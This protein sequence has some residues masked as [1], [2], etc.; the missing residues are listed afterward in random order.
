[1]KKNPLFYKKSNANELKIAFAKR[2]LFLGITLLASMFAMVLI[3]MPEHTSAKAHAIHAG[4]SLCFLTPFVAGVKG[5]G[6]TDEAFKARDGKAETPEAFVTRYLK[7][8]EKEINA[9]KDRPNLQEALKELKEKVE[10]LKGDPELV[11]NLKS[12]VE[13]INLAIVSIQDNGAKGDKSKTIRGQFEAWQTKNKATLDSIKAG[14]KADLTP[15][16]IKLNSPMTPANTYNSSAY[17][18]QVEYLPG[19]TEIVRTQP[20]FWD[21]VRKLRTGAAALVWVNKKNPEGAA[22]F[23]GPGVAKPGVSFEIATEISNA[24]KIAASEKCATELL[25]DIDGFMSWFESELK[26]QLYIE[27]NNKLM[28]GTLS[29]TVPA[30]IQTISV[31]YSLTGVETTNPNNWDAIIACVAQLRA[32]F[33]QGN[34]VAFLNP[35]DY[36]NM[37]LTKAVSQGQYINSIPET[38]ATIVEDHNI[39]VG[40]VQVAILDNYKIYIYQDMT[41]TFGWENDDFTKNLVTAICEMRIH[42]FYSENHI[43]SFIYDEL[44]DIK[45]AITAV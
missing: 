10:A 37:K 45:A 1:M 8:L 13:K 38:G 34:V 7:Y 43:G 33:L 15:L 12:E 5:E 35:I 30:G 31:P 39:P 40:F 27:L 22:A 24:K 18:P 6:E 44:A 3:S 2:K 19:A 11:A 32:A 21:F 29:S 28:T 16:T 9:V 26:Y 25:Q 41:L 42:Q 23:I 36:A 17:L 14:N 4:T 20:T